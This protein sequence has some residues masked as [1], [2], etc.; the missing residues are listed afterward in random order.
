M[1]SRAPSKARTKGAKA[2][3]AR[4]RRKTPRASTSDIH[5]KIAETPSSPA[6]ESAATDEAPALPDHHRC[7]AVTRERHATDDL[8]RFVLDPEGVVTPDLAAKLPGRGVWVTAQRQHVERAVARNAFARSLKRPATAPPA[9]GAQVEALLQRR[10]LESLSFATKAGLI[11]TGFMKVEAAVEAA[12]LAALIQA[13]DG[14]ADGVERLRRKYVAICAARD[15]APNVLAGFTNSQL[16]LAIGRSNVIHAG[17]KPS[18]ITSKFLFEA[19]R[20]QKFQHDDAAC[21]V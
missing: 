14:A 9:L 10:A 16:S 17:I 18:G 6:A 4:G 11:V 21:G 3:G 19:H 5:A 7:C 2:A 13:S 12:T 20:W 15:Q 1:N 8:I